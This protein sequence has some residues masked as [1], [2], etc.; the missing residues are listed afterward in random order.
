MKSFNASAPTLELKLKSHGHNLEEEDLA[1][2][3]MGGDWGGGI[4]RARRYS[5]STRTASAYFVAS[6]PVSLVLSSP[7]LT[8]SNT[9]DLELARR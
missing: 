1:S 8:N 5:T 9:I 2:P 4:G 3:I 7:Q 6:Q